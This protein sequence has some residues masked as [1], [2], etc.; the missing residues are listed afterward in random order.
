MDSCFPSILHDPSSRSLSAPGHH[1]PFGLSLPRKNMNGGEGG[2]QTTRAS[3]AE[4]EGTIILGP[5]AMEHAAS[6]MA[7]VVTASSLSQLGSQG[8]AQGVLSVNI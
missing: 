2:G 5:G 7:P 3:V 8:G 1:L 6:L 4:G